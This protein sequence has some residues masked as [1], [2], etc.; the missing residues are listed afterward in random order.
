M[1]VSY[2][3]D[4]EIC[5]TCIMTACLWSRTRVLQG[6]GIDLARRAVGMRC[7]GFSQSLMGFSLGERYVHSLSILIFLLNDTDVD[8][9]CDTGKLIDFVKENVKHDKVP[10]SSLGPIHFQPLTY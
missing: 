8:S 5:V 7:L 2:A 3:E 1:W 9:W 4:I 10:S 6:F